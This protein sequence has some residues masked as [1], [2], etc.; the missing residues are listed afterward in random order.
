MTIVEGS[1]SASALLV[2]NTIEGKKSIDKTVS[3]ATSENKRPNLIK[4]V[5]L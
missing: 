3:K 1:S 4:S 2:D 5:S